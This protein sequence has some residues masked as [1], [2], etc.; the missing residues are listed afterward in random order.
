MRGCQGT[1]VCWE[2]EENR[3]A[4]EER[5]EVDMVDYVVGYL[6]GC[7]GVRDGCGAV[8]GAVFGAEVKVLTVL[9]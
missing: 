7:A 4:E 8:C 9:D 3:V 5:R 1:E 2:E 6:G